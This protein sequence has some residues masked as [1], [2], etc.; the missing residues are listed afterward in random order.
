MNLLRIAKKMVANRTVQINSFK[1]STHPAAM[2]VSIMFMKGKEPCFE[3]AF[4]DALA[5]SLQM[6][7][8]EAEE[9][10]CPAWELNV[11]VNL[12]W[13]ES[14]SKIGW[15]VHDVEGFELSTPDL[16]KLDSACDFFS[17]LDR[18]MDFITSDD[19]LIEDLRPRRGR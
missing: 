10:F 7:K 3:G 19:A 16:N 13:D 2:D 4:L 9:A 6:Q 17:I 14:E 11:G 5:S 1:R 18:K 8:S 12:F 15:E